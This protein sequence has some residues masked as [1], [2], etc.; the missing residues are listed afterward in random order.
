[1]PTQVCSEDVLFSLLENK[2]SALHGHRMHNARF[3]QH[4]VQASRSI[5]LTGERTRTTV[6]EIFN[7]WVFKAKDDLLTRQ[8]Q[9]NETRR[10]NVQK[11]SHAKRT[12]EIFLGIFGLDFLRFFWVS[13]LS[14]MA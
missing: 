1:M 4:R 7:R 12:T 5:E 13:F 2:E 9:M 11:K 14:S 8:R 6:Y 3:Q 10:K